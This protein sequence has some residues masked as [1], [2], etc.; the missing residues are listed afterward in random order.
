MVEQLKRTV[1]GFCE[2]ERL[3]FPEIE[4]GK[5]RGD[6]LFFS[7]PV[8]D[9]YLLV[10]GKVARFDAHNLRF[11]LSKAY[12]TAFLTGKFKELEGKIR[13]SGWET[14]VHRRLRPGNE[15][16]RVVLKAERKRS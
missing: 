5:G 8:T 15:P 16:Y 11:A 10:N 13:E 6:V 4:S 2:R 12:R 1:S 9:P 7:L 14:L 3:P